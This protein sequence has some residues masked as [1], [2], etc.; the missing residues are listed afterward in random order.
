MLGNPKWFKPAPNQFRIFYRKDGE[1]EPDFVVETATRK[2]LCEPK[3]AREMDDPIVLE[4]AHAAATWCQLASAHELQHGGKPW[5]Y[6]LIP[7][8]AIGDSATLEGLAASYTF[9]PAE[10]E[11]INSDLITRS[12]FE[13]RSRC[14]TDQKSGF[15]RDR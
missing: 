10:N 12:F 3:M 11:R 9:K 5:T 14:L 2:Y 7:H 6:L 4:K 15:T 1:Y 13:P 8:D